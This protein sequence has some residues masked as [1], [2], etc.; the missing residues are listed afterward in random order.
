MRIISRDYCYNCRLRITMKI[1][2]NVKTQLCDP[3]LEKHQNSK[4]DDF[5]EEY[6]ELYKNG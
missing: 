1:K 4:L 3:C 2:A 5:I 6:G